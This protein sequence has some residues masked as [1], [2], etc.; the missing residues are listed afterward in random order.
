[1]NQGTIAADVG[2]GT[3]SLNGTGNQN[4][5]SLERSTAAPCRYKGH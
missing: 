1:V 3:I 2:G 5:G 4:A